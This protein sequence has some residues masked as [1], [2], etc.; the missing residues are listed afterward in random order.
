MALGHQVRWSVAGP[1]LPHLP[2]VF[3]LLLP[4]QIPTGLPGAS[5]GLR[6]SGPVQLDFKWSQKAPGGQ[7]TI[8]KC[9][10]MM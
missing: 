7:V 4:L 5:T 10:L 2:A 9:L 3:L 1:P 8:A 6:S